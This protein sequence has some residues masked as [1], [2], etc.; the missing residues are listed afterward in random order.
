M[1]LNF[2]IARMDGLI[3]KK[4]PFLI[5]NYG[6]WVIVPRQKK[7]MVDL[8]TGYKRDDGLFFIDSKDQLFQVRYHAYKPD[9][10]KIELPDQI[11]LRRVEW[12]PDHPEVVAYLFWG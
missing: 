9:C 10:R 2:I 7:Y 3:K 5:R 8:A 6:N 11:K 1:E 12:E 4:V